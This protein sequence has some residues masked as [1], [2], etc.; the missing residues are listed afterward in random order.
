MAF[1]TAVP[2]GGAG[3]GPNVI[4]GVMGASDPKDLFFIDAIPMNF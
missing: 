1:R 3:S 4:N 2:L